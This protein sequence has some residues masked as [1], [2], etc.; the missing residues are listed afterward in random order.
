MI[1]IELSFLTTS[2][3]SYFRFPSTPE[4]PSGR[5]PPSPN[6]PVESRMLRPCHWEGNFSAL[7]LNEAQSL[8]LGFGKVLIHLRHGAHVPS[9]TSPTPLSSTHHSPGVMGQDEAPTQVN[10]TGLGSH[11]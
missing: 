7:V 10:K 5:F 8:L 6:N 9:V 1:K 2:S 3:Y 4:V 11:S